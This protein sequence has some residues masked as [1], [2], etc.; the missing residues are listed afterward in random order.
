M[1]FAQ[2]FQIG[3]G[4]VNNTLNSV[5]QRK[6]RDQLMEMR[7]RQ[8]D[9]DDFEAIRSM[10]EQ[11]FYT[12]EKTDQRLP[13]G[14]FATRRRELTPEEI[15][16]DPQRLQTMKELANN[17]HFRRRYLGGHELVDILQ[18]PEAGEKNTSLILKHKDTGELVPFTVGGLNK[19]DE[20]Y[21]KDIPWFESPTGIIAR[22]QKA[23]LTDQ[24]ELEGLF[25]AGQ[26]EQLAAYMEAFETPNSG[27]QMI[28]GDQQPTSQVNQLGGSAQSFAAPDYMPSIEEIPQIGQAALKSVQV[29]DAVR[30][31]VK[32]FTQA[33]PDVMA[34]AAQRAGLPIDKFTQ[35]VASLIHQES[36]GNPDAISPKGASGLAQIMP[37]TGGDPGFGVKPLNP[38]D[39]NDN[40]RLGVEYLAAM[41][42]HFDGDIEKGLAAYNAGYKN[43]ERHNGIPPFAETQGY[44]PAILGRMSLGQTASETPDSS[45]EPESGLG[46]A[47]L[48][49]GDIPDQQEDLVEEPVAFEEETQPRRRGDTR[50]E[51]LARR[52]EALGTPSQAPTAQDIYANVG[53]EEYNTKTSTTWGSPAGVAASLAGR[54]SSDAHNELKSTL[55]S[56]ADTIER[57]VE[58]EKSLGRGLGASLRAVGETIRA[59]LTAGAIYGEDIVKSVI[60][61][62]KKGTSDFFDGLSGK[63]SE[64]VAEARAAA[65]EETEKTPEQVNREVQK[66]IHKTDPEVASQTLDQTIQRMEGL[67][68]PRDSQIMARW[69]QAMQRPVSENYIHYLALNQRRG[70]ITSQQAQQMFASAQ[71]ASANAIEMEV[72]MRESLA[73]ASKAE[74]DLYKAQQA[75]LISADEE[76]I[77][78]NST[79]AERGLKRLATE[80]EGH[81][82]TVRFGRTLNPGNNVKNADAARAVIARVSA[83]AQKYP[84][85][86]HFFY[87]GIDLQRIL[88]SGEMSPDE[89]VY[90]DKLLNDSVGHWSSARGKS[91]DWWALGFNA[92]PEDASKYDEIPFPI[93]VK[94]EIAPGV[95]VE[96]ATDDTIRALIQAGTPEE[97]LNNFRRALEEVSSVEELKDLLYPRQP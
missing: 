40:M 43:V 63:E 12:T 88:N 70:N 52:K 53:P 90:F 73:K 37:R 61:D 44:V 8:M 55:K 72:K 42:D 77:A 18:V 27:R 31:H 87:G 17:P 33:R 11:A 56:R 23:M 76:R 80:Y 89:R 39:P 22:M 4:V 96:R 62:A 49:G 36:R 78:S 21:D 50:R 66:P 16:N 86:V 30:G 69:K 57:S 67:P 47:E 9:E 94:G 38:D 29:N 95:S 25:K 54:I 46:N 26:Q 51:V 3:S 15:M 28:V 75:E 91:G 79:D 14:S 81:L 35:L 45:P 97:D 32:Q 93:S 20:G 92:K 34:A 6:E 84:H 64:A 83:V 71:T 60:A 10:S 19:G 48:G 85:L 41:I 58:G 74:V 59:P 5:S 24:R 82:P 2:G 13:D 68:E 65:A 7:Q 1:S